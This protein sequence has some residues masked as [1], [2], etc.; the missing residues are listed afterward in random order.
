[1][2]KW[3]ELEFKRKLREQLDKSGIWSEAFEPTFGSSSGVGDLAVQFSEFCF[4]DPELPSGH[5]FIKPIVFIELKVGVALADGSLKVRKIRAAQYSWKRGLQIKGG[6]CFTVVGVGGVKAGS[7]SAYV[8]PN[9]SQARF[10]QFVKDGVVG[11]NEYIN[12]PSHACTKSDYL[13]LLEWERNS[14]KKASV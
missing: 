12:W 4:V 6:H 10:M 3:S 7:F 1:M 13:A 5:I 14:N 8:L 9:F 2:V 11:K